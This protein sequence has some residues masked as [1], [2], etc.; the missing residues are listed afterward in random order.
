MAFSRGAALLLVFFCMSGLNAQI[1]DISQRMDAELQIAASNQTTVKAY[2][3]LKEQVDITALDQRLYDENASLKDRVNI[4]VTTLQQKAVES[5]DALLALLNERSAD[6]VHSITSLWIVNMLMLEA[7]VEVYYD[8]MSHPDVAIM[9]LV[10]EPNWEKPVAEGPAPASI[11]GGVEPGIEAINARKMWEQGYDGSGCLVMGI[12][13]GVNGNHP[14]VTW[15]WRGNSV[16]AS[17]AWFGSGSFPNDCDGGSHGTHTIGTMTGL[18]PATADTIGVAPGAEWIASGALCGN[19]TRVQAFQ[20]AMDPDGNPATIADV[21]DAIGCSWWDPNGGVCGSNI[22]INVLDALEAAGIAV[23]FSAGNSGP[24]ISTITRPKNTNTTLV[25][26]W[27]TG[28][29]NGNDPNLPIA[30]FSSRGP[31]TCGGTG[32]LLIKPEAS[33]P[34]VAVRSATG[35]SGY[36]TKNG[37][38]M[39]APHVVGAIALLRQ[40]FPNKTGYELKLALLNTARDLGVPGEDNDYGTGIIDV[41]AAFLSMAGPLAAENFT[42]YSDYQA[43]REISL[44]WSDPELSAS[45]DSLVSGTYS[46]LLYRDGELLDSVA[47][48][49]EAFL[50]TGLTS[51]TRYRY[52][53]RA[54]VDSLGVPGD[55]VS[56]EWTAGGARQPETVSAFAISGNNAFVDLAWVNPSSNVDGTPLNDFAGVHIYRDNVLETTLMRD[57]SSAGAVDVTSISVIPAG[58]YAWNIVAFD[59]DTPS[60]KSRFSDTQ[61]TPLGVPLSESFEIPGEPSRGIWR[62][63]NVEVNDRANTPPNGSYALNLNGTP[64][65]SDTVEMRPINLSNAGAGLSISYQWQPQGT[66]NAPEP[67]DSLRLYFKDNLGEWY[68]VRGY[69]GAPLMPFAEEFIELDSIDAGNGTVYHENFQLRFISMGGAGNFPNDDWFIGSFSINPSP[70]S[71]GDTEEV[72]PVTYEV[73][74]N[75]PNPFNPTTMIDYQLPQRSDVQLVVYNTLGQKVRT[76]V[77][78]TV[79]AGTHSVVWDG[80]DEAGQG[81]ASGIYLYRFITTEYQKIQKM[82]LMK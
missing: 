43:P 44:S 34:G 24:G 74:A 17:E 27:A 68:L 82:I 7:R 80:K 61:Y 67:G 16:P 3:M 6:E 22:Y 58:Y 49:V 45:G 20:W 19:V 76:L 56:V 79:S 54:V 50:D 37:T 60:N 70:L 66:G 41:W 48:N 12:D 33:A 55:I 73:G 11:P 2:V 47:S 69:D 64:V 63:Y 25:N 4:V 29:L 77:N 31:S 21:P 39:A 59:N 38:S 8:L 26:F 23:I 14:A 72:I 51:G 9:D 36:G 10:P 18:D 32:S 65:G 5:Q 52:S 78:E 30:N 42:A 57:S 81:V 13:S 1:A 28:A 75:Y 53:L 46:M 15:K 71:V 35:S 62:S 40:A